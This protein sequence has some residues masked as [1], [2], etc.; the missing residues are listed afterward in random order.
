MGNYVV[1][2]VAGTGSAINVSLGF[3][4]DYVK[5]F[6]PNDAGSLWPTLEWCTGM[7][8]ASGFKTLKSVDSGSTGN[9]SSNKITSNGISTYAGSSSAAKG[10]TIGA[11]ADINVNGETIYYLALANA[12]GLGA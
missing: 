7:A 6:N 12:P 5:V 11:D 9:A 8:A 1:G 4:P 10:F 2:S 3:I